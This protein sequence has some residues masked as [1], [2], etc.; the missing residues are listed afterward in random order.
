MRYPRFAWPEMTMS[1]SFMLVL[2]LCLGMSGGCQG[3]V[4]EKNTAVPPST[5]SAPTS[6]Q[7]LYKPAVHRYGDY[8]LKYNPSMD[9]F[10]CDVRNDSILYHIE[11]KYPGILIHERSPGN[12]EKYP[13]ITQ[14]NTLIEYYDTA[15]H[16]LKKRINLEKI[17]P[18][19]ERTYKNISIGSL[20]YEGMDIYGP[21][22]NCVW[23]KLPKITHYHTHNWILSISP[24]GNICVGFELI[25]MAKT[26]N[27][28]VGWEQ[29]IMVLDAHGKDVMRIKMDHMVN[30]IVTNN[31]KFIYFTH[32][33]SGHYP[34]EPNEP[35]DEA[36]SIY[37]LLQKK[38]VYYR[39]FEKDQQV[40]FFDSASINGEIMGSVTSTYCIKPEK[41]FEI[42]IMESNLRELRTYH[43]SPDEAE[44]YLKM[45]PFQAKRDYLSQKTFTT[46]KF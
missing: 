38:Q 5:N 14:N 36:V 24:N 19:N 23:P 4:T 6:P 16:K 2:L 45:K 46:T 35:C 34:Y 25:K 8:V 41:L 27:T 29:T 22:S 10:E 11:E 17:T 31:D 12:Y 1:G 18:Y 43:F 3:Q 39:K 9:R 26:N 28:V 32:N 42:I 30:P 7:L 37:D 33:K 44:R 15:T 13:S 20:D 21:D 40:G